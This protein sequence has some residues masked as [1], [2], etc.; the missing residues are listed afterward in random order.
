[1]EEVTER[2][3]G[4]FIIQCYNGNSMQHSVPGYDG[5]FSA[6]FLAKS[7]GTNLPP[8]KWRPVNFL[9]HNLGA[10]KEINKSGCNPSEA[11][12]STSQPARIEYR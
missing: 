9:A 3:P 11:P 5:K 8:R 4:I 2:W 10:V 6:Y 1:M 7:G 12:S